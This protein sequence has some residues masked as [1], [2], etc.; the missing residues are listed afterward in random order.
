MLTLNIQILK[1]V[2]PRVKGAKLRLSAFISGLQHAAAE[3]EAGMD[4]DSFRKMDGSE[5]FMS[6]QSDIID[7]VASG[8]EPEVCPSSK[9]DANLVDWS[10]NQPFYVCRAAVH[11]CRLSTPYQRRPR[12][13]YTILCLTSL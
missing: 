1:R 13:S 9:A 4:D 7:G 8:S 12:I 10:E 2:I 5:S 6:M 3:E 11:H